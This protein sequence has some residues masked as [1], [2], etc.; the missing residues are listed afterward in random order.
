[1]FIWRFGVLISNEPK[2]APNETDVLNINTNVELETTNPINSDFS[3]RALS[4][5]VPGK[6]KT[7]AK[8]RSASSVICAL[9]NEVLHSYYYK[10]PVKTAP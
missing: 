6:T 9:K 2:L 10:K 4:G 7:G 1:V 3:C 8:R 5:Y